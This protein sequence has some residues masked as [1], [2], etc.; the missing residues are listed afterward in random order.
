V[1]GISWVSDWVY[2]YVPIGSYIYICMYVCI[3][4]SNCILKNNFDSQNQFPFQSSSYKRNKYQ[5]VPTTSV[6]WVFDS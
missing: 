3:Y 1:L 4:D 6:G 2:A 5:M